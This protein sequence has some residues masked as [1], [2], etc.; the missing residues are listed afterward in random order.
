MAITLAVPAGAQTSKSQLDDLVAHREE[1]MARTIG[2][3][4]YIYGFPS[5]DSLRLMHEW[6]TPGLPNSAP[7]DHFFRMRKLAEPGK[8][9]NQDGRAKTP[10]NDTLYF[11]GFMDLRSGPRVVSVPDTND[12]YYVLTFAD[13]YSE[14]QHT[15]RRATGTKAQK[16]LLIGP[17]WRGEVPKGIIPIRVRTNQVLMLGRMLAL[18]GHDVDEADALI[19]KVSIAPLDPTAP[20]PPPLD[21]PTKEDMTTIAFF[22]YLNEF[23]RTNPRLPGE[24]GL[25]DQFDQIG[26]GPSKIFA[27]QALSPATI[28]GL[29]E[30]IAEGRRLVLTGRIDGTP[31]WTKATM[32]LGEYGYDYLMRAA[33]E[34]SGLHA[35]LPAESVYLRT[36]TDA[37]GNP[38]VGSKKYRLTLAAGKTPPVDAFWSLTPYDIET[39]DMIA[40]PAGIYS[41]GDRTPGLKRT[42]DGSIVFAIQKEKPSD[43]TLNWLPVADKPF[44]LIMRMYQPKAQVLDGT[45]VLP[46]VM[47]AP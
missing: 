2:T 45:Y 27:S 4:A 23:L 28:R 29:E 42:T 17:G 47:E 16:V 41:V 43:P 21:L 9:L 31:G 8:T 38:L 7:V 33:V 15:G 36:R 1:A 5:V 34:Y 39:F 32:R 25:M 20:A 19:G 10:N 14:V 37:T 35:N 24:E 13:F 11:L 18:P 12:R 22:R 40:N 3:M 6:T 44:F 30:G 26:I 46:D